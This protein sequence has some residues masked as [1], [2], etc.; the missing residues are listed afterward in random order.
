MDF[1]KKQVNKASGQSGGQS[2]GQSTGN[3]GGERPKGTSCFP[4]PDE[5]ET[6]DSAD[7]L[8][9]GIDYVEEHEFNQGPQDHESASQQKTDREIEQGIRT[10]YKAGTGND[11]PIKDKQ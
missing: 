9:K 8:D 5:P 1:V 3:N 11:F 10:G 4:L 6:N 7:G 2:G